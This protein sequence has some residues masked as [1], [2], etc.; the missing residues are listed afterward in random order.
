LWAVRGCV[1][2]LY[3]V[4]VSGGI[5]GILGDVFGVYPGIE[6]GIFVAMSIALQGAVAW[7]YR[8]EVSRD[9]R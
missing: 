8:N 4:V 5:W 2:V 3:W 7:T 1:A 9:H 6:L